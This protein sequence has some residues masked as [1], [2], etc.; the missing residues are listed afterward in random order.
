MR[1]PVRKLVKKIASGRLVSARH[2]EWKESCLSQIH[3]DRN[4]GI[5]KRPTDY[6]SAGPKS[7]PACSSNSSGEGLSNTEC[8]RF[9]KAISQ[10]FQIL[11][12]VA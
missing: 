5:K 8:N 4:N 1:I 3:I 12:F 9:F 7:R 11:G 10:V 6:L 2:G